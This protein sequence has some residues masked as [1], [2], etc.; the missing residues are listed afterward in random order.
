MKS[1]LGKGVL[2]LEEVLSSDLVFYLT[3]TA[4]SHSTEYCYYGKA[5]T[6]SACA[7]GCEYVLYVCMYC[8]HDVLFVSMQ[9]YGA[10]FH[11]LG[12]SLSSCGGKS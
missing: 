6:L 10:V 1:E 11:G 4:E 12:L 8:M 5:R 7:S 3:S 2:E 9:A